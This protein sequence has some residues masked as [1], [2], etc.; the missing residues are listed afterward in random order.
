MACFS[1]THFPSQDK[2]LRASSLRR[3]GEGAGSSGSAPHGPARPRAGLRAARPGLTARAGAQGAAELPSCRSARACTRRR[4]GAQKVPT[5][6]VKGIVRELPRRGRAGQAAPL[7]PPRFAP[8]ERRGQ[9]GPRGLRPTAAPWVKREPDPE[10][11]NTDL[12]RK[13]DFSSFQTKHPD[14]S[15]ILRRS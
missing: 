3:S 5:R 4:E 12:A 6:K 10:Q 14:G 9:R 1:T 2:H 15:E 11:F 7:L 13:D 8:P